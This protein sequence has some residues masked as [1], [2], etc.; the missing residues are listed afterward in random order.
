MKKNIMYEVT[1]GWIRWRGVKHLVGVQFIAIN[2]S[3]AEQ[4]MLDNQCTPVKV[5]TATVKSKPIKIKKV[6]KPK[7]EKKVAEE[8]EVVT[9]K[10]GKNNKNRE[11]E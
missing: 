6:E 11:G 3:S 10:T 2:A 4:V 1:N 5:A 7:V 8:P 9:P